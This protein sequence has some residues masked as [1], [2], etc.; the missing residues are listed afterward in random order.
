MLFLKDFCL[1]SDDAEGA[2]LTSFPHKLEMQCYSHTNVYPFR[3][4]LQKGLERLSFEP[5]T[6]IYGGNGSGKSTLL[7]IIAEKLSLDRSAP[8]NKTP[9]TEEYLKFCKYRLSFGSSVPSGSRIIT[10]DDVFD[11]M[12][13]VRD[14]NKNISSNVKNTREEYVELKYK[15]SVKLHGLQD[16]EDLRDQVIA[17]KSSGRQYVYKNNGKEVILNSNG[18][19]AL[20]F[21]YNKI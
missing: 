7:N 4:F 21:F 2:Y 8:F 3:I 19:T 16:Y 12:L 9:F 17:R 11:Y 14:N 10:S 18:E 13:N 15:P 20:L 6:V 1:P 5:V